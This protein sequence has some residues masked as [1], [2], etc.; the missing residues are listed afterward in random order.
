MCDICATMHYFFNF[1]TKKMFD[2]RGCGDL[3]LQII[4]VFW[5][6]V[7][8]N[9]W[10]LVFGVWY[11]KLFLYFVFC[12]AKIL[13]FGICYCKLFLY[14]VFGIANMILVFGIYIMGQKPQKPRIVKKSMVI[15]EFG[16]QS[17]QTRINCI[18][19]FFKVTYYKIVS[20]LWSSKYI[21]QKWKWTSVMKTIII[22][23]V[24]IWQYWS[25]FEPT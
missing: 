8:Q 22:Y 11:S 12:I 9:V 17:M 24:E 1:Y 6:L 3:V 20:P 14:L 4:L 18:S 13:V 2:S 15:C 7:F 23:Y 16:A 5:Y 10:Y 19:N 21:I 25:V